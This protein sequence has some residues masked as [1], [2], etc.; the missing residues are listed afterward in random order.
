MEDAEKSW[1]EITSPWQ[2]VAASVLDQ[3]QVVK[4]FKAILEV[5]HGAINDYN[6]STLWIHTGY[7]AVLS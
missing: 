3:A 6:L 1:T 4:N 2:L 5:N 7:P